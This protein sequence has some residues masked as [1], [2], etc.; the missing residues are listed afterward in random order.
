MTKTVEDLQADLE[1]A[2][3][4]IEKLTTKNSELIDREKKA[5]SAA[6]TAQEAADQAAEETARKT[7]DLESL[8]KQISKR[9]EKQIADL[10]TSNEAAAT[11]LKTL[12]IDNAI[13]TTLVESGV[14]A[15]FQK[16]MTAL[17]KSGAELKD[18][19][20][21]VGDVPLADHIKTYLSGD[22]GKHFVAAPLNSGAGATGS[23]GAKP[24]TITKD[25]VNITT[26]MTMKKDNPALFT[27]TVEGLGS[28]FAYLLA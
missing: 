26:L 20:A 17:M 25:N 21:V 28:D 3:A 10:T 14:P 18:G 5:K 12:L 4:S 24:A 15:Q 22:E 7:N 1:K 2:L 19:Q 27:T 6:E 23:T 16:A 11:Q 8:E 9:F 13:Q